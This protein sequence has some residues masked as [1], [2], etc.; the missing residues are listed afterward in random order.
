[1][2]K[3]FRRTFNHSVLLYYTSLVLL[4]N[5]PLGELIKILKKLSGE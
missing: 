1:M 3:F 4:L 5:P 2:P